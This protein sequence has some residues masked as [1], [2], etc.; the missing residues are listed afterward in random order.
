MTSW[1]LQF[2]EWISSWSRYGETLVP[3]NLVDRPYV[4]KVGWYSSFV[5][6]LNATFLVSIPK[7]ETDEDFR[8]FMPI[9]FVGGN[10]SG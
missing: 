5:K 1:L 2:P 3:K 8:N 9:N 10:T 7:R 6:T 4:I